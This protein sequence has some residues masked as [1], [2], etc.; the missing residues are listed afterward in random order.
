MKPLRSDRTAC[1]RWSLS[2]M[3]VG[4]CLD[5]P[6]HFSPPVDYYAMLPAL[7]RAA[8]FTLDVT[9]LLLPGGLTQRHFDVWQAGGFLLTATGSGMDIFLP[10]L[11]RPSL[12]A[13]PAISFSA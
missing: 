10:I 5:A 11:P 7:Y 6:A 4:N 2:E 3:R 8:P 9:S 1:P 12:Y 13:A